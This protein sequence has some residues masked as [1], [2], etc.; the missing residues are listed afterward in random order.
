MSPC[1]RVSGSMVE[2]SVGT[3]VVLSDTPESASLLA[4]ESKRRVSIRLSY[5]I[6]V[7]LPLAL[8]GWMR[9]ERRWATPSRRFLMA[10]DSVAR[11]RGFMPQA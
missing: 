4:Q 11:M 2:S 7:L 9:S 10:A 3:A 1:G 5:R 8:V 6:E